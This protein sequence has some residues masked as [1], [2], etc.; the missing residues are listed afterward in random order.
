MNGLRLISYLS[1]LPLVAV[2]L[3]I[4]LLW[5]ALPERIASHFG[6]NGQPNAFQDKTSFVTISLGMMA[7]MLLLFGLAPR[8]LRALP[9]R[10]INLPNREYWLVPE[11]RELAL[12]KLATHLSVIGLMTQLFLAAVYE[13][14]LEANLSRSPLNNQVMFGLLGL[15]YAG[16]ITIIVRLYRDFR[17]P[18]PLS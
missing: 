6:A 13:L 14:A 3:R 17:V 15:L 8:L 4:G 16:I 12:D 5:D 1:P 9:S 11:R 2:A 10:T 18:S 7:L